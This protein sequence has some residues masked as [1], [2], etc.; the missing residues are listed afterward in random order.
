LLNF[1]DPRTLAFCFPSEFF[2][3]F[4]VINPAAAGCHGAVIKKALSSPCVL[5]QLFVLYIYGLA[6]VE[7]ICAG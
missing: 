3:Y 5:S 2:I 1:I 7:I 6:V 4:R